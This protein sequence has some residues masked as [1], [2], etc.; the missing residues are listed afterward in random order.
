MSQPKMSSSSI[1]LDVQHAKIKEEMN[2]PNSDKTM[3]RPLEDE[4][5]VEEKKV[6]LDVDNLELQNATPNVYEKPADFV[7]IKLR[8]VAMLLSYSGTGYS[9]MQRNDGVRTIE[10]DLFKAL[11]HAKLIKAEHEAIP[12]EFGFQRA[13]RTDKGVSAVRQVVSLKLPEKNDF[14]QDM[15]TIN[16]SLPPQIR[17]FAIRRTTKGFNSKN[18]C[19]FRTYSYIC[20][21]FTFAP[22]TIVNPDETYR[23]SE[24]Q[25]TAVNTFL[26]H[27]KGTHN[28]HNF[29]A[30]R[31][32]D[33]PSCKRYMV[34]CECSQPFVKDNMEFVRLTFKGQSFMLHQIRKMT[35][36]AIGYIRGF[37]KMDT[38]LKAWKPLKVDIPIAPALGLMLEHVHYEKYNKV[39]GGD[40]FHEK[41]DW[42]EVEEEI[43]NFTSEYIIPN[44]VTEEKENKSMRQWMELLP[45][46]SYDVREP[47][48]NPKLTAA[49]NHEKE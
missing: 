25:V 26:N 39:F 11:I 32:P 27:Y 41:L 3:K 15:K 7:R 1:Q 10:E 42:S 6:K 34:I 8:K 2:E 36:L 38:L 17:V 30:G 22:G 19:D 4:S 35:G 40:G 24:E 33:D 46:H 16:E 18:S 29:T 14:S 31:K 23:I 49:T 44:V 12:Q 28:Y 5:A 45:I 9:G 21:S 48:E 37:A 43:N 20:P 47:C 13:A